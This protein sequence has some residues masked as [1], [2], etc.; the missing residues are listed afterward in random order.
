[1]ARK[2]HRCIQNWKLLLLVHVVYV[3]DDDDDDDVVPILQK[4]SWMTLDWDYI[5]SAHW[6][7]RSFVPRYCLAAANPKFH[8]IQNLS[9][10]FRI[11]VYVNPGHQIAG[12]CFAYIM[13]FE[14]PMKNAIKIN[15]YNR[16]VVIRRYRRRHMLRVHTGS[17]QP[18]ATVSHRYRDRDKKRP[19][20]MMEKNTQISQSGI[21]N[22]RIGL[23][24]ENY[25]KL[26]CESV[27]CWVRM[28][29]LARALS[30]NSLL[31][32]ALIRPH[33]SLNA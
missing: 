22:W 9:V 5:H 13:L 33:A 3:Y 2:T 17:Y 25:I 21:R 12:M 26:L 16:F 27:G 28:R 6:H 11:H 20:R 4:K 10:I 15:I 29:A 7:Y 24:Y 14:F 1:M 31:L 19:K 32:S 30:I 8:I 23:A 18:S